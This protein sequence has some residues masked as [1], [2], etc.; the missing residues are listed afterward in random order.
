MTE[1]QKEHLT[2]FEIYEQWLDQ[3]TKVIEAQLDSPKPD[4]IVV[5]KEHD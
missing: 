3:F 4:L 1:K 5:R 2:P